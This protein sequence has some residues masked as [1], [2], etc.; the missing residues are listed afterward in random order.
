MKHTTIAINWLGL[1]AALFLLS[2]CANTDYTDA[3]P[4]V[5]VVLDSWLDADGDP[6]GNAATCMVR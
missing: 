6:H 3:D 5:G 4:D 2:A 1:C